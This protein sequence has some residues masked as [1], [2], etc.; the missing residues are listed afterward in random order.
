M[1]VRRRAGAI[2]SGLIAGAIL[3]VVSAAGWAHPAAAARYE[4]TGRPTAAAPSLTGDVTNDADG[5]GTYH[6]VEQRGAAAGS[7][8]LRAVVANTSTVSIHLASIAVSAPAA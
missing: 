4:A 2:S 3:L 7:V 6:Q 1:V 5:D 8:P